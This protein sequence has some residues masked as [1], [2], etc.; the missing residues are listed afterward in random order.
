MNAMQF[1]DGGFE[2]PEERIVDFRAGID[3]MVGV[4]RSMALR[5]DKVFFIHSTQLFAPF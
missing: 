4:C 3:T 1:E 5:V 2:D